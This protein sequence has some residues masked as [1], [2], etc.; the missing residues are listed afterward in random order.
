M[1]GLPAALT[2]NPIPGMPASER[3][4][5]E[6]RAGDERQ[7]WMLDF[8]WPLGIAP[9]GTTYVRDCYVAASRRA[10]DLL[11]LPEGRGVDARLAGCHLY[12][13]AVVLSDPLVVAERAA[14][15]AATLPERQRGFADRWAVL[16]A[17][18]DAEFHRLVVPEPGADLARRLARLRAARAHQ[19]RAWDVHFEVMYPLVAGYVELQGRVAGWGGDPHLVPMLLQG[20]RT[21]ILDCDRGLHR[22]AALARAEG[23]GPAFARAPADIGAA[24]AATGGRAAAWATAFAEFLGRHGWRTEGV[25]AV[26][27]PS[28]QEDPTSPLGTISSLLLEGADHDFDA[29]QDAAVGERDEAEDTVRS[30]LAGT[31]DRRQFD[32][33]LARNRRANFAWWNDEHNHAIDLRAT[34]PLRLAAIDLGAAVGMDAPSDAVLLFWDELVAV[35]TGTRSAAS[36]AGVVDERRDHLAADQR[37]RA[38][39]PTLT[40]TIPVQ[41]SDPI[42]LE[43]FGLHRHLLDARVGAS[44]PAAISGLGVSPGRA[45]GPA[46]VLRGATA[47]HELVPGDVLVC[48]ATSPNWTPAFAKAAA[49]VCDFGGTLTHAAITAREYRIP[50]VVG[51]GVATTVIRDG[52]LLHVDGDLGTV[53][54]DARR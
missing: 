47:L 54:I 18:L 44:A 33:L 14:R 9:L 10:A 29:A 43:V 27:L 8:H 45:R 51:T 2:E 5:L 34:I 35:A 30:Q 26:H 21:K 42:L 53:V 6:F 50:C 3:A 39:L 24:L 25:S 22:L 38:E 48:E 19:R 36:L 49:C 46:R 17:E 20:E 23:L 52:D 37:R 13:A 28:W 31:E 32:D 7:F 15:L 4:A 16:E 12:G 11:P 1:A 40:G 41:V